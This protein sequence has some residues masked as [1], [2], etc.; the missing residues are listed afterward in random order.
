[1][2]SRKHRKSLT[3]QTPPLVL[4]TSANKQQNNDQNTD[5]E[6]ENIKIPIRR[7]RSKSLKIFRE[8]AGRKCEKLS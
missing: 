4:P 1:M 3:L 8:V 2:P 5:S 7:T 6:P